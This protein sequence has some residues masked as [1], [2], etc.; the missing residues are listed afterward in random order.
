[1]FGFCIIIA[2]PSYEQMVQYNQ[3]NNSFDNY[4]GGRMVYYKDADETLAMDYSIFQPR[5]Y[6]PLLLTNS[7]QNETTSSFD[8]VEEGID[9]QF[10]FEQ[11]I[12]KADKLDYEVAAA[13]GLLTAIL[14][15]LW[16]EEFSLVG[17]KQWGTKEI[18]KLV[19]EVA[20][21]KAGYTP[22]GTDEKE[23]L[24][25]AIV[26]LE[27]KYRIP[28]DLLSPEFGDGYYHHFR[29][30]VHHPTILG[31]F[32]S[33]LSQFT[34]YGFGTDV[35]GEFKSYK[36]PE[37]KLNDHLIGDTFE[38]KILYGTINWAFHLI[39]DI[40]GSSSNPG[41]GTGIPGPILGFLKEMSS[42]PLINKLQVEYRGKDIKIS[43]F[44][45]K[46]FDGTLFAEHDA[47]G[48]IIK[49]TE[50]PLDFRTE[51]GIAKGFIKSTIP[52]IANECIVRSFYF[53]RRLFHEIKV[54]NIVTLS[55][56]RKL[57]PK[58]FLP[59]DNR[60]LTRMLTISSGTFMV[61]VTSKDAVAAIIKSKGDKRKFAAYFFLNINY[62]GIV[63]FTFAC[64]NDAGYI[65][66]DVKEEYRKYLDEKRKRIV[67]ENKE[68][69]GIKSLMLNEMQTRIL[70]SLK[71]HK[72]NYDIQQTEDPLI[73]G[74][75][76]DWLDDWEKS[77]LI[78][79]NE[80]DNYLMKGERFLYSWIKKEIKESDS[81]A[82]LY[83][84]VLELDLFKPY[85]LMY[86]DQNIDKTAKLKS[87]YLKD[88]FCEKQN[89]ITDQEVKLLHK[90]YTAA[91]SDITNK[92]VKTAIGATAAVA[93]SAASGGLALAFAPEIA[94]ALVGGSFAGLSG[95][96]LTSASLAT[97][98]LGSLAAGGLGMAGGTAIIAGGG[99]LLGVIGSGAMTMSARAFLSSKGTVLDECSKLLTFC[100]A[101]LLNKYCD[102]KTVVGIQATVVKNIKAYEQ[103]LE[104]ETIIEGDNAKN[105]KK[106]LED[107]KASIKH[108]KKC[109]ELLIDSLDRKDLLPLS[110]AVCEIRKQNPNILIWYRFDYKGKTVFVA[111]SEKPGNSSSDKPNIIW[112]SLDKK[113]ESII[114]FDPDANM[115]RVKESHKISKAIDK[116]IVLMDIT[117]GEFTLS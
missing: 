61:V 74:T 76:R 12:S 91:K 110:N 30:F 77:I 86:I 102:R 17:A 46:V 54:N 84:V 48:K 88:V 19:V 28:A 63:R 59:Y 22:K 92:K 10:D 65:A 98:G 116:S 29:D 42:L 107:A 109:N 15:I 117:Q 90:S 89:V 40:D 35:N 31:L 87:D 20:K 115:I 64:K 25:K 62:A 114:P 85:Y 34:G 50:K 58:A 32:F 39:S 104:R 81:N 108:I 96:A 72:V 45:Q 101:I 27:E 8:E 79:F 1:M 94:V 56:I 41:R 82:W 26:K 103:L 60:A 73:A 44:L 111:S 80:V 24:R 55:D 11:A 78:E 106:Q 68:I 83:L 14:D 7:A 4:K 95:A 2:S 16:V 75:K 21:K 6:S 36:I 57:E 3:D 33:I 5:Q 70:Y 47:S 9:F 67:E 113:T 112:Y 52:V 49:G 69:P 23:I 97:I 13:S 105:Q 18:D 43:A 66:D 99:T 51:L 38:K 100:R 71:W 53:M 37:D 93:V